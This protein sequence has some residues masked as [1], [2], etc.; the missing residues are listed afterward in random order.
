MMPTLVNEQAPVPPPAYYRAQARLGPAL[1]IDAL[2]GVAHPASAHA[3][4][5][6]GALGAPSVFTAPTGRAR[7]RPAHL[8]RG[9]LAA[10]RE[11][12]VPSGG[13][14][15]LGYAQLVSGLAR[16]CPGLRLARGP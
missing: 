15:D 7:R 13:C 1:H 16:T 14:P 10:H 3:L 6:G 8:P 5:T 12:R 9:L 2:T 11:A 4:P